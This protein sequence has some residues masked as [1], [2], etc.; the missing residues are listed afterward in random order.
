MSRRV[1]EGEMPWKNQGRRESPEEQ[2]KG[3]KSGRMEEGD[4]VWKNGGRRESLA[5]LRK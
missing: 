5:G 3:K 4:K 1:E 2:R